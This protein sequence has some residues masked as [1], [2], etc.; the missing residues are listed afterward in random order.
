MIKFVSPYVYIGYHCNSNCI[1]CS[2][3]DES[4]LQFKEK[5]FEEIKKEILLVRKNYDFINFM[6]R[7]TTLRKDLIQIL[8][9]ASA[10][11]FKQVG[12]TTNGRM[13][14]YESFAKEV[15]STGVNQVAI[16]INGHN[17]KIHD[18]QSQVSG[19]FNQTLAGIKNII[20]FKKPTVSLLINFPL[21]KL[22]YFSLKPTISLLLKLGV[23][24]INLLWIAPI[25]TRSRTKKIV[26]NMS[27][28]G[29]YVFNIIKPYLNQPNLKLLLIEFLPCSLP[30]EA[31]DYFFPCLEKNSEKVRIPLCNKCHYT[32]KCIGVLQSYIN[33]YGDK[34]FTI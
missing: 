34:E 30:K 4:F 20:K 7:E 11:N 12:L 24:E 6:G 16:S 9:F 10:L 13:F 25:S 31:R 22:N 18:A 3:A 15:L 17:A 32:E 2:E 1:F 5:T 21:N 26:M 14:V 8:K 19:S 28:L 27:K 29:K 33:L 23:R